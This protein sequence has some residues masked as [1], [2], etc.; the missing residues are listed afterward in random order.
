MEGVLALILY[1]E[2]MGSQDRLPS[3]QVI[4]ESP[5]SFAGSAKRII[6]A[7]YEGMPK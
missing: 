5:L 6:P 3:E 4:I 7:V 2:G 1:P